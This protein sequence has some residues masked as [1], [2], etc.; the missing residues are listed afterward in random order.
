V[1]NPLNGIIIDEF[2]L[3]NFKNLK[4]ISIS[5]K[6]LPNIAIP[7]DEEEVTQVFL[8]GVLLCET[9]PKLS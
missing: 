5:S 9:M 6:C 7:K 8:K 4:N 1:G 2:L 3:V